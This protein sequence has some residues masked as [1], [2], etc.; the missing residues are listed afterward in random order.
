[1]IDNWRSFVVEVGV[2]ESLAMLRRD[3][4]FWITNSDG[5]THIVLVLSVN[6]RD[7]QI[8]VER[9]EEVLR[10][11]PNWSTANYSHIPR[12]MQS[13]TLNVGVDYAGPPL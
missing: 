1:M 10:T 13:L 2:S 7:R 8:L 5:R 6:Q 11:R 3:V 4:A 9:W 12:N